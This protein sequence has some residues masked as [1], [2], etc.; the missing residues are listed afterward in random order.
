MILKRTEKDGMIK[1]MYE[2]S[3]ILASTYNTVN[4][5]LTII[6]NRGAQYTYDEISASE[7]MRFETADS[8]GKVL[9]SHIKKHNF[10][11]LDDVTVPPPSAEYIA[12]LSIKAL[13]ILDS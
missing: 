11:K 13:L 1:A 3:N 9:N 10:T 5:Q 7:Y 6:F 12:S 8:Q 2:S 4:Q